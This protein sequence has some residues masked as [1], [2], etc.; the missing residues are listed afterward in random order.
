MS[1]RLKYNVG[2]KYNFKVLDLQIYKNTSF[3]SNIYVLISVS[4]NCVNIV[5]S[6]ISI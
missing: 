4:N 3:T 2:V 6:Q 1:N 5:S